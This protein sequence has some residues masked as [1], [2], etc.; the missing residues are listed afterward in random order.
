MEKMH[1]KSVSPV[2]FNNSNNTSLGGLRKSSSIP[3]LAVPE[4]ESMG[5]KHIEEERTNNITTMAMKRRLLDP[6]NKKK[7]NRFERYSSSNHAQEQSSEENFC[8]SKKDST[9]LKFGIDSILKNKNAEKVPKGISNAGR[10]QDERFTEACTNTSSNV[11]PL[12]KYFKP[13]SNDQLGARRT[14]TSFSSSSEA[15]DSKSCCTN[16]NEEARYKYRVIDKRKSADS[17]WSEDAT[18]NEADDPDDHINQD[19][20]DLAS[21]LEQS[22]IVALEILK[23]KRL[24]LDS[25]EALNDLTPYDQLSRTEDQQI[26]RRVEMMNHQAFARE[27]NE[28]PRSFSSGLQDP[29][30]KNLPNA[31]LPFYMQP[32]LR[33]YYN[34]QK[35]IYHKKLLNRNDRFYREANVENDNYKTEESLRSPSETKQYSPD[36]S[37]FYP[38]R[39]EDSNGSRNLKVD[40]EEGDKEANKLFKDLCV[41][42]GDRLSNALSYGRKDYNGLSTSQTSG[43]RFL[44]F[45]DKGIQ[46]GSYYQTGERNDSLAGPLKNSGM[47]FDFPPKFGSNNSSSNLYS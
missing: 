1:S 37:T 27:N 36:A 22:R 7:Q 33:A 29:F 13:S 4:C 26:S 35:Y 15:S 32:Y 41:S 47:S 44:N 21:T 20:C 38:I 3:T 9:V 16:N 39:T 12:S 42:V 2:P 10:I 43:N 45:S 25:S 8:R 46:A 40:V 11:N 5:N 17:D 18:G 34:I 19:N 6:Q 14:A 31:F 30:A 24:R 23:N 28:W